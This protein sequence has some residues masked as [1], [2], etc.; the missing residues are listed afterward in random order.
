MFLNV[1]TNLSIEVRKIQL[2]MRNATA[3]CRMEIVK[4]RNFCMLLLMKYWNRLAFPIN[5]AEA[6]IQFKGVK[7]CF[8]FFQR[9]KE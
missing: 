1:L 3:E 6:R 8:F 5:R 2:K 4:M 9:F 7:K